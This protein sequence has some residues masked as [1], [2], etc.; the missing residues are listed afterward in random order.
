[1]RVSCR[2]GKKGASAETLVELPT[3]D[4]KEGGRECVI[5]KEEMK[6]GRD[7]CKLPCEH[8]FHWRCVL[9]WLKN[10]DM[11]PCCRYRLPSDDVFG[12]IQRLWEMLI[13]LGAKQSLV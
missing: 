8:L 3:V 6:V 13:K 10:N 2:G 1:M 5:C 7:V 12:E 9:P 4:L 11:C